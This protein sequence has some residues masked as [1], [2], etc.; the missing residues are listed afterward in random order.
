VLS[1]S[2]L[3]LLLVTPEA[4]ALRRQRPAS[5]AVSTRH[6]G[7]RMVVGLRDDVTGRGVDGVFDV[8]TARLVRVVA[9]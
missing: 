4:R 1:T 9:R 7:D 6:H 8:G 5:H 2:L 3:G